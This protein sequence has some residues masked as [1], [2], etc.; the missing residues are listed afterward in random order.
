MLD[1]LKERREK[2]TIRHESA[3]L[4]HSAKELVLWRAIEEGKLKSNLEG[5]Y[6]I[7]NDGCK[8]AYRI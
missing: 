3:N 7:A 6:I 2:A 5:R 4:E 8:G 1:E